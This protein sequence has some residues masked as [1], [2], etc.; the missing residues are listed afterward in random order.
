M[1]QT[2]GYYATHGLKNGFVALAAVM[3]LMVPALPVQAAPVVPPGVATDQGIQNA[4]QAE[5]KSADAAAGTVQKPLPAGT[6]Q[7]AK[8]ARKEVQAS[9]AEGK[10]IPEKEVKGKQDALQAGERKQAPVASVRRPIRIY[11]FGAFR[12]YTTG[13]A[14]VA[15]TLRGLNISA[16]GHTVH[17]APDTRIED[18]MTIHVLNRHSFLSHEEVEIPF[19]TRV[20]DDP[21]LKYGTKKVEKAGVKGK[22][23]V[24][25]ENITRIGYQQKIELE[26]KRIQ[27]PAEEV[28]RQGI[29]QAVWTPEGYVPY[30]YKIIAEST[31]YTWGGGASGNTS[32]GLTPKRGIIAVDP[33]RIPYY[34]KM[35]IPGYGYAM[36]GDTGGAINGH[37]IDL[38]MDS[39]AEC[40]QWGRREVEVY[41]L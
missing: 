10:D 35:Y 28:V 36:A 22:D 25:Y 17:P 32:L 37:R 19:A 30:K 38:F 33:R 7:P 40:Y 23:L 21:T 3:S 13:H 26:R 8:G 41:I 4:A 1:K 9:Q 34:T 27:E 15:D 14:T 39:L 11:R 6:L 31:A 5:G 24:T 2:I 18:G 12:N 16:D 20:I 29:A